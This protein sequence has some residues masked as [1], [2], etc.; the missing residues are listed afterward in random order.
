MNISQ[1]ILALSLVASVLA[2]SVLAASPAPSPAPAKPDVPTLPALLERMPAADP[3]ESFARLE[4]Y[5][6]AEDARDP[7]PEAARRA[8]EVLA[9]FADIQKAAPPPVAPATHDGELAQ[10]LFTV[11][12]ALEEAGALPEARPVYERIIKDYPAAV[13]EGG[14]TRETIASQ[15]QARLNW[16][17]A[18]HPWVQKDLPSLIARL[19]EA[20]TKHD[21]RALSALVS[22]IGFW[23]GPFQSEGTADDP[24]R[25]IKLLEKDWP[26]QPVEVAA[27][28]EPFSDPERQVFLK[29]SGFTGQFK[30]AYLILEKEPDGWQW[31]AVALAERFNAEPAVPEPDA[32]PSPA[33][34]SAKP[35]ASPSAR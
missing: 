17:S 29:V 1:L 31:I 5:V 34:P 27:E 21:A 11:G 26:A 7:R 9:R 28:V 16:H 12:R 18:Q 35:S 13:W 22:R 30:D 23:S 6:Q 4:E 20:F 10:L 19:R 14:L 2:T 3:A 32:S 15:A 25:V 8:R 33:P 24:D